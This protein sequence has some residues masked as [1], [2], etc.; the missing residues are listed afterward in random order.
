MPTRSLPLMLSTSLLFLNAAVL[1]APEDAHESRSG[2]VLMVGPGQEF[3]NP[4]DAAMSARSGD[5]VRIAPGTYEDCAI[6]P[7]KIEGLTIEGKDVIIQNRSC[8]GK[9]I[10][11]VD[12]FDVVIRGITFKGA[13]VRDHNGAGIRSEGR[14]LTVENSR[15]IDD[16]NGILSNNAPRSTIIIRNS[17]FEGNGNCISSCAHGIYINHVAKLRVE[18]SEFVGTHEGHHIKSRAMR[19]E[20]VNNDIHDGPNGDS[21]YLIDIPNGGDLLITGNKLE[22]GPKAQNRTCAITI[23]EESVRR[24]GNPTSEI[25]IEDNT[26]VN[27]MSFGTIFVRNR[28]ETAVALKGNKF[29][30]SVTALQGPGNN[31]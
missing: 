12:A 4:S 9:G 25:R 13:K 31:G 5:T 28:S 27:D 15:F 18:G 16:E 17:Y 11:V 8:G 24:P 7:R 3:A 30:G 22:K 10:F 6:W 29:Q 2:R 19:T 1:A 21:S 26:F 20:L 14:N 23:G